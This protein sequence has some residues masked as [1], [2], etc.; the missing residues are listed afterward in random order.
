M[1]CENNDHTTSISDE[2]KKKTT[3]TT[4]LILVEIP[5]KNENGKEIRLWGTALCRLMWTLNMRTLNITP[6]EINPLY[7]QTMLFLQNKLNFMYWQR[8][9]ITYTTQPVCRVLYIEYVIMVIVFMFG[10][11]HFASCYLFS[12]IFRCHILSWRF[13]YIWV[14]VRKMAAGDQK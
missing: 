14:W 13:F 8:K 5:M 12:N 1:D 6:T 2:S 4:T 10:I 11:S 7:R 3:V 9:F